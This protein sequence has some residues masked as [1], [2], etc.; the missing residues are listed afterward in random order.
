MAGNFELSA[1]KRDTFGKGHTN[2]LRRLQG[3]MPAIIYGGDNSPSSINISHN[4]ILKAIKNEAFFSHILTIDVEGKKEQVVIKDMH[5]HPYK[6]EILHMDFLRIK[7][8]EA[9]VMKVPLHFTGEELAPGVKNGGAVSHLMTEVE[10][11]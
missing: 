7:D 8:K 5:R 4:L 2:R 10:I 3:L 1:T 11:K 9:I 6:K